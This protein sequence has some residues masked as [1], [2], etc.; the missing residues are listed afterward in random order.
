M[1]NQPDFGNIENPIENEDFDNPIDYKDF[2]NFYFYKTQF[3]T[4]FLH[5]GMGFSHKEKDM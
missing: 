2:Y 3:Y 1:A 4:W 5:F